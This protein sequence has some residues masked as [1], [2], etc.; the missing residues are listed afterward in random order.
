MLLSGVRGRCGS[1]SFRSIRELARFNLPSLTD[2]LA[3]RQRFVT[4]AY[5]LEL[6]ALA[7]CGRRRSLGSQRA[8]GY[9]WSDMAGVLRRVVFG[10]IVLAIA[11]CSLEYEEHTE[12]KTTPDH[13]AADA[14]PQRSDAGILID[15]SPGDAAPWIDA[16]DYYCNV[17]EPGPCCCDPVW[18]Q[19]L[20]PQRDAATTGNACDFEIQRSRMDIS[21]YNISAR[22]VDGTE[23]WLPRA[24]DCDATVPGWILVSAEP[25]VG[26]LCPATCEAFLSGA[27]TA[28]VVVHGCY[29]I[30]CPPP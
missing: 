12:Q 6:P 23:T 10:C 8:R 19:I 22:S 25:R 21:K 14:R 13:F 24:D 20:P 3:G 26:R 2:R 4:F 7:A 1:R 9:H 17:P 27:Y 5:S 16:R 11:A 15:A 29:S 30:A 28:L 18:Q